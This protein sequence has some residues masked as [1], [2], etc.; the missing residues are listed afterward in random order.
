MKKLILFFALCLSCQA[1]T[2]VLV[3]EWQHSLDTNVTGY[4]LMIATTNQP[5]GTNYVADAATLTTG[6]TNQVAW[7]NGA[8]GVTYWV[9][10][11][12]TN[13]IGLES[14]PSAVIQ[15]SIP[16]PPTMLKVRRGP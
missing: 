8:I 3:F 10:A 11:T 7:S 4:K 14:D 15:F 5:I 9:W 2:P 13:A 1:A 6:Y 12:A 16:T